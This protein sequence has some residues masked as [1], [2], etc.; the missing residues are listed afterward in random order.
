MLEPLRVEFDKLRDELVG[1]M[2]E[3]ETLIFPVI[4]TLDGFLSG[5][6]ERPS[7]ETALAAAIDSGIA[8]HEEAGRLLKVMRGLTDGYAPPA[9]SCRTFDTLF[10]LMPELL[11]ELVR[12][13]KH[14]A[15]GAGLAG[16]D[17]IFGVSRRDRS[18]RAPFS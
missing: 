9:D 16:Q 14:L 12:G 11:F 4:R 2:R 17:V 18:A 3:E 1:H 8:Q 10:E 15:G 5:R 7:G 13:R 6:A